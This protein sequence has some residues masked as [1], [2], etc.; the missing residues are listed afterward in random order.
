MNF[1]TFV[2]L[3]QNTMQSYIIKIIPDLDATSLYCVLDKP[4]ILGVLFL[5]HKV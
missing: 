5:C 2:S 1:I 4:S 3:I